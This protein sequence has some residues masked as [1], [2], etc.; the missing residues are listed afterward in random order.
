MSVTGDP[1]GEP[2]KVGVALVDVLWGLFAAVGILAAL[3]HR[4]RTAKASSWRSTCCAACSALVNQA[5]AYTIA[6]VVG[7]RDGQRA[8]ERRAL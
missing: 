5:S 1:G 7:R 3:R 6:G 2:M 8:P 4:D